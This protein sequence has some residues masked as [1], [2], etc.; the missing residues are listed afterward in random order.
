MGS[1]KYAGGMSVRIRQIFYISAANF[2]F[3][4]MFNI[5]LIITVVTNQLYAISGLLLLLFFINSYVAVTGVLCATV[6]FSRSEWVRTRSRPLPDHVFILKPNLQSVLE[7]GGK[8][9]S[10]AVVIGKKS[11]TLDA[12]DLDVRSV[13][14]CTEE[15]G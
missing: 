12:D 5:V 2:V 4:L 6:W 9:G 10:D 15:M 7:A 14:Q 13:P 8:G 11:A 3:P 1:I